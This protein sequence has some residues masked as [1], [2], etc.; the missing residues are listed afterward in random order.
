MLDKVFKLKSGSENNLA[1][2]IA[3]VIF[4]NSPGWNWKPP[5]RIQAFAPFTSGAIIIVKSKI[6]IVSP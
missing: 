4:A 3:V 1:K 5:I 6:K 2:A